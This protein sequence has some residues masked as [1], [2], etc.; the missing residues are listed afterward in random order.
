MEFYDYEIAY[1]VTKKT[2]RKIGV[3]AVCF[4]YVMGNQLL[5]TPFITAKDS[6]TL[7][8]KKLLT[9][10]LQLP[11]ENHQAR[12]SINQWLMEWDWAAANRPYYNVW[13]G[14]IKPLTTLDM[15]KVQ[16]EEMHLP[17]Y[18][19][20]A[21]RMPK[22]CSEF[23]FF[24]QGKRYELQGMLIGDYE[25]LPRGE[26]VPIFQRL[27][28]N[29][30]VDEYCETVRQGREG[31]FNRTLTIW[32]D[33]QERL[34]GSAVLVYRKAV[35]S[36][37]KTLNEAMGELARDEIS[38][39][40]GLPIYS[41]LIEKAVR[42]ACGVI[43]LSKHKEESVIEPD[44]LAKDRQK[45]LETRD[46]KYVERAHRRGKIGWDV[47]REV[48]NAPHYRRGHF[49]VLKAG[50]ANRKETRIVWRRG[51]F[52]HREVLDRLPT[53]VRENPSE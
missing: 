36:P 3:P 23:E 25:E 44:V 8:Y 49:M 50:V 33:F 41:E 21:F 15:S 28:K 13:P 2:F 32:M 31:L 29:K 42:L 22:N 14:I 6:A 1:D 26:I 47:G 11:P 48:T 39:Q 19:S 9:A 17:A 46:E 4:E 10:A 34:N 35:L 5:K 40:I 43:L 24:H 38:M 37:N 52:V 7:F 45:W 20:I 12:V 30:K 18:P 16:A 53:D 51:T 27:I